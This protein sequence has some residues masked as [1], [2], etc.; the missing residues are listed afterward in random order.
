ML[1]ALLHELDSNAFKAEIEKLRGEPL[2]ALHRRTVELM[3]ERHGDRMFGRI[4]D[5]IPVYISNEIDHPHE[6]FRYLQRWSRTP[7]LETLDVT[8][9]DVIAF[10]PE[11]DYFGRYNIFYDG[12]VLTWQN[13]AQPG[14]A[15]WWRKTKAE[16]TFYHEV[17]HHHFQHRES[18]QVEEQERE[19]DEYKRLMF[20]NAH[21]IL[22]PVLAVFYFPVLFTSKLLRRSFR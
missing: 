18:G 2:H 17:G 21:P 20:R 9:I 8:R 10:H 4:G 22:I 6:V 11:L 13:E 19:A 15:R 12:L 1:L 3:A 7:G 16:L 5:D 14:F